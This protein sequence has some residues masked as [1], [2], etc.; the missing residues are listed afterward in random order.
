MS[1]LLQLIKTLAT[2]LCTNVLI[3]THDGTYKQTDG[4]VMGSPPESPLSNIW[5][6]KYRPNIRDN[7]K[8]FEHYM[9]DTVRT[10]KF[11]LIEHKLVEINL[12]HPKL[13]LQ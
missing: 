11:D 12:L 3:Q 10:I 13:Q 1:K 4:L 2:L 6:L 7:A 9:D 5:L 8:R